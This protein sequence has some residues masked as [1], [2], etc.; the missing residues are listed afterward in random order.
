VDKR[1]SRQILEDQWNQF[2]EEE[3]PNI[4]HDEWALFMIEMEEEL[5]AERE[6]EDY[7]KFESELLEYQLSLLSA[8]LEEPVQ[9]TPQLDYDMDTVMT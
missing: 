9:Q 7:T 5:R 4:S 8:V 6:Y 3:H 2:Y 1:T